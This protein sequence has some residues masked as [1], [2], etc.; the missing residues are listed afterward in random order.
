MTPYYGGV[1]KQS[2][3]GAGTVARNSQMKRYKEPGQTSSLGQRNEDSFV[4]Y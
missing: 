4:G 1:P 3:G 2:S